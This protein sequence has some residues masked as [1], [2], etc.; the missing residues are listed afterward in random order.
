MSC[1]S[2]PYGAS[3]S[4]DPNLSQPGYESFQPYNT[5]YYSNVYRSSDGSSDSHSNLYQS[6]GVDTDCHSNAYQ[7]FG[8]NANY[9]E[10]AYDLFDDDTGSHGYPSFGQRFDGA[11]RPAYSS[12]G[13]SYAYSRQYEPYESPYPVPPAQYAQQY[14][15]SNQDFDD[16]G[17]GCC[18]E[19]M[20]STGYYMPSY[21]DYLWPPVMVETVEN[22]EEFTMKRDTRPMTGAKTRGSRDSGGRRRGREYYGSYGMGGC[23]MM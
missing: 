1:H 3:C 10:N 16:C 14:R 2:Q 18:T 7:S 9:Q 5:G 21:Y 22:V 17:G 13:H 15:C 8:N 6:Y 11:A 4:C 23:A 19:G 20:S 12:Y